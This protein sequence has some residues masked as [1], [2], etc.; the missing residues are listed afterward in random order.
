MPSKTLIQIQLLYVFN[1]LD[2]NS[3][4]EVDTDTPCPTEDEPVLIEYDIRVMEITCQVWDEIKRLWN[5]ED[6]QVC[7]NCIFVFAIYISLY[8]GQ[9]FQCILVLKCY[10]T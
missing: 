8:V 1:S 2:N 10:I 4:C 5:T 3:D 7:E 9:V 6:C